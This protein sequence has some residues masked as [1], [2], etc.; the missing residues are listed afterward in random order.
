MVTTTMCI[1]GMVL[2]KAGAG[3]NSSLTAGSIKVGSDFAVDLWIVEAESQINA[4]CSY[5][6]TTNYAAA[7]DATKKILQQAVSDLAAINCII[8]DMSGYTSRF[9]AESMINVLR[10]NYLRATS[11]LMNKEKQAFISD[12]SKGTIL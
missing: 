12:V 5:D 1:S 2:I 3:V 10:D 6:W 9:E 8:Y 4:R 7:P 11:L